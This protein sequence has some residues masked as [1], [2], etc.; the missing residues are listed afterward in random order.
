[1]KMQRSGWCEMVVALSR[2]IA[3]HDGLDGVR[4]CCDECY[5]DQQYA[6]GKNRCATFRYLVYAAQIPS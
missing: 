2:V 3:I 5:G 6:S 1:M 4:L